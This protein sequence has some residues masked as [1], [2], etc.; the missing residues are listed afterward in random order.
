MI[1]LNRPI[2]ISHRK[3]NECKI[4]NITRVQTK[5]IYLPYDIIYPGYGKSFITAKIGFH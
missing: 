3:I 4:R 1:L 2:V 5:F